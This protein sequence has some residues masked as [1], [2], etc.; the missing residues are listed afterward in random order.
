[1]FCQLKTSLQHVSAQR[2]DIV[3]LSGENSSATIVQQILS[4]EEILTH[5]FC[6]NFVRYC[7]LGGA[8][9]PNFLD[10]SGEALLFIDK[11]DVC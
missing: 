7:I 4:Q 8:S 3:G 1:M 10:A 2:R 6:A 5:V 11:N 9:S